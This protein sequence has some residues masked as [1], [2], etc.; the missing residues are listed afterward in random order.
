MNR[1]VNYD[2]GVPVTHE[3][4]KISLRKEQVTQGVALGV[5]LVLGGLAIAGPSGLLAW[6]ENLHALEQRQARIAV[7]EKQHQDLSNRVKLLDPRHA[8]PD[9][10]G[11]LLRSES[12]VVHDDEVV[13]ILDHKTDQ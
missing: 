5:L 13:L 11:E 4:H 12:N 2:S 10:V 6:S 1:R 3:G 8:D 9:M 7:L